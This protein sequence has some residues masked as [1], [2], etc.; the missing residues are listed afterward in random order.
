MS[1]TK[2]FTKIV[3]TKISYRVRE[4]KELKISTTKVKTHSKTLRQ[5]KKVFIVFDKS[6]ISIVIS[7]KKNPRLDMQIF[8]GQIKSNIDPKQYLLS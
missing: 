3:I 2:Y 1:I 4:E 6:K 8:I 7:D 5:R